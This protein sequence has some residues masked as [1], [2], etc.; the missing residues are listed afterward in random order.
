MMVS[1]GV[2]ASGTSQSIGLGNCGVLDCHEE[3]TASQ[4]TIAGA[5]MQEDVWLGNGVGLDCSP[6][7]TARQS[8]ITGAPTQRDV[9]PGSGMGLHEFTGYQLATRT[10]R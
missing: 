1:L 5:P 8:T 2:A 7:D 6:E 10:L 4:S 9:W 3:D